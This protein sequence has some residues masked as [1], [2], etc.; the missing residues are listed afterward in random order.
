M[1]WINSVRAFLVVAALCVPA[2]AVAAQDE[3]AELRG[4][5]TSGE[6]FDLAQYRGKLVMVPFWATWCPACRAEFPMWQRVYERYRG[7]G[8]E[9]VAVS[10]DYS[11]EDPARFQ[12]ANAYTVP[13][14]WRFDERETDSFPSIR[15]TPTVYF[16]GPDGTVA[17]MHIGRMS[18]QQLTDNI[19]VLLPE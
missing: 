15:R 9:M 10:I 4:F 17:L 19:E 8:F 5:L 18:E 2:L 16:I 14:M 7:Q 1:N 11:G 13:M 3:T 12:R 6:P